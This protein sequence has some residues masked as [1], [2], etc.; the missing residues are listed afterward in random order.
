[1]ENEVIQ[2]RKRGFI[3][4]YVGLFFGWLGLLV[5]AAGVAMALRELKVY[6]APWEQIV[7]WAKVAI[8]GTAAV[9]AV[10]M[11]A[12]SWSFARSIGIQF[13]PAMA[14]AIWGMIPILNFIP[15]IILIILAGPRGEFFKTK[16]RRSSSTAAGV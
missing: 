4:S 8:G 16:T 5:I 7:Y 1:M 11:F 15:V 2:G 13:L 9:Y 10:V 14:F 6:G 12:L 3:Q